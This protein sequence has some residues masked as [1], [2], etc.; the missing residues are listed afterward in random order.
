MTTLVYVT[1]RKTR[2][3]KEKKRRRERERIEKKNADPMPLYDDMGFSEFLLQNSFSIYQQ[4]QKKKKK[5]DF[6]CHL[7]PYLFFEALYS[8]SNLTTTTTTITQN[9]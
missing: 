1:T 6:S 2:R 5:I 9:I 8:C 7:F 3:N 4:Q